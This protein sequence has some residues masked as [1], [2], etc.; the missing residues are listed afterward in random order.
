MRRQDIIVEQLENF[1]LMY[2]S[3][4]PLIFKISWV[5]V[6]EKTLGGMLLKLMLFASLLFTA[7]CKASPDSH[8]AFLHF[9]SKEMVLIPVSCAMSRTSFH[10]S[11][12]TL[13]IR[14]LDAYERNDFSKTGRLH[15]PIHRRSLILFSFVN[16]LIFRFPAP[17]CKLVCSLAPT[18]PPQSQLSRGIA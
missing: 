15:I 7:I 5:F 4:F 13:S 3:K 14:E 17:C 8:F 18:P 1:I 10:S 12:G 9:F 11:S 16:L 6:T 2:I